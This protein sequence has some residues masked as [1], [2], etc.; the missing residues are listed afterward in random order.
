M[1]S[2]RCFPLLKGIEVLLFQTTSIQY[3]FE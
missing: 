2:D 1:D 3:W